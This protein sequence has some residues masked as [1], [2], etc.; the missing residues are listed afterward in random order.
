[1]RDEYDK[2]RWRG[3]EVVCV[4]PHDLDETQQLVQEL[5][6]PFP[7]VADDDRA[8]FLEYAVSSRWESLGQRPGMYVID[9]EGVIFWSHV[10]RQQW[11]IP[12]NSEVLAVLDRLNDAA[13]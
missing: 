2:F 8:V 7:V 4:A 13:P 1:M 11:D 9:R 5:A 6:L 10:G 3:A 12:S